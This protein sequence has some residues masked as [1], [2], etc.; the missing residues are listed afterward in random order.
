MKYRKELYLEAVPEVRDGKDGY[1][2]T[3][4]HGV[5]SWQS[6]ESFEKTYIKVKPPKKKSAPKPP[7]KPEEKPAP[8]TEGK[9]P[10]LVKK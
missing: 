7:A 8:K 5:V 2:K 1:K 4:E 6:K 10:T 9:K 3:T